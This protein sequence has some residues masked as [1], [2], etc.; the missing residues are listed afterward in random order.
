[1]DSHTSNDVFD[2]ALLHLS[3]NL[4]WFERLG[5][6]NF[7]LSIVFF[8][9]SLIFLR[10]FGFLRFSLNIDWLVVCDI[11]S[12]NIFLI[13]LL[14]G[15][16]DSLLDFLNWDDFLRSPVQIFIFVLRLGSFVGSI[17]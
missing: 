15:V 13:L 12:L 10:L 8:L 9:V 14:L 4:R 6:L 3:V 5:F 11:L 1:M 2:I 16:I 7:L 17:L